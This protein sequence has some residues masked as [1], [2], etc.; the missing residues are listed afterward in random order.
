MTDVQLETDINERTQA[1]TSSFYTNYNSLS[2]PC[3]DFDSLAYQDL[4]IYLPNLSTLKGNIKCQ[5][6]TQTNIDQQNNTSS[7]IRGAYYQQPRGFAQN[8]SGG[9]IILH[10]QS[11]HHHYAWQQ[12]PPGHQHHQLWQP[13]SR[14]VCFPHTYHLCQHLQN[15]HYFQEQSRHAWDACH[16]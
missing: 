4:V 16:C 6:F 7:A 1:S 14:V 3:F 10:P 15:G 9:H 5:F 12:N 13:R 8:P 11:H 2:H